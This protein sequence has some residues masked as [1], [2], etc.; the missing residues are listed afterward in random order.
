MESPKDMYHMNKNMKRILITI[1]LLPALTLVYGS[2][3]DFKK[4][5]YDEIKKVIKNKE[6]QFYYP[7]L[8]E[9]YRSSDTTLTIQ[10][11]RVLYYGFLFND[12]YSAYGNSDY[13]DSVNNI[14]YQDTLT[15][16]DYKEIIRYEKLILD[17]FPFNLRDLNML[18]NSYF[19]LG[20][21]LSTIQTDFKL[22]MVV[23]TI[24]STG[25][26]KSE[27]TAW[28][29]ISVSHEYDILGYFGFQFRGSQSLT[30]KGCDYLEVSENEYDIKG[31]YF[32]VN[33][34]LSKEAELFK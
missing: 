27:K 15:T 10:Y 13:V 19:Q 3:D 11:L 1:I 17:K 28:H 14:L 7:L 33:M 20:D 25:D 31:F 9:R 8:L 18:A 26:G 24:M 4:P 2:K 5:D 12:S 23:N 16:G 34:I 29:V 30:N 6:S 21:T 32:D 22:Q